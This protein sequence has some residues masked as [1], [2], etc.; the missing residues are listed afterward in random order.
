MRSNAVLPEYIQR[1]DDL[2]GALRAVE[3]GYIQRE[4]QEAAYKTQRAVEKVAQV[5]VGVNQFQT[6]DVP[7]GDLLRVDESVRTEQIARLQDCV[8]NATMYEC[9][10]C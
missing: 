1:I 8:L 6:D 9:K 3:E 5:V 7:T 2:G 10:K 4:I